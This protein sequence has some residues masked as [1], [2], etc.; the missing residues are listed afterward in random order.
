[1]LRLLRRY[2]LMKSPF[3]LGYYTTC[4][5]FFGS[6]I[7]FWRHHDATFAKL[8]KEHDLEIHVIMPVPGGQTYIDRLY[9]QGDKNV[10]YPTLRDMNITFHMGEDN[11][12][13]TL[14]AIYL[15]D[16]HTYQDVRIGDTT[17]TIPGERF[18]MSYI[19]DKMVQRNKPI[20]FSD[21]D[22]FCTEI[23][24]DTKAEM[25]DLYDLYHTYSNFKITSPFVNEK[26]ESSKFYEI[27]FEVDPKNFQ[28]VVPISKRT[29]LLRY[30]GNEY[31]RHHFVPI[32]DKLSELG[33]V[34]VNGSGWNKYKEEAPNVEW[35]PRMSMTPDGVNQVYGDSILGLTG[36]SSYNEEK[37]QEIYLYRWKEYLTAGTLIIPENI[38]A[39]T[40]KLPEGNLTTDDLLSRTFTEFWDT[41]LHG[42]EAYEKLINDQREKALQFFGVDKW[43]PVFMKMF[44]M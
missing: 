30:V 44:E 7:A 43:V 1:M 27:P 32:F 9:L 41:F 37:N 11:L 6:R 39:Y 16:I 19:L 13:D 17:Y 26:L 5:P 14:D 36:R 15:D 28:K 21:T 12:G 40:S 35:G 23:L 25:M 10:L 3:K 34:A 38:E 29:H 24:E 18:F 31:Y 33:K 2:R 4:S 8:C 22:G 42:D 20:I